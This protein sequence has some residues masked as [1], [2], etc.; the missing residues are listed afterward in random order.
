MAAPET[1]V[2]GHGDHQR[3]SRADDA[4]ELGERRAVVVEV[5]EHVES[6]REVEFVVGERQRLE[7]AVDHLA[8]TASQRPP[9]ALR[10]GLEPD[11]GPE[12]ADLR[13]H[14]A[15]PAAGVEDPRAGCVRVERAAGRGEHDRAPPAIPPMV[16]LGGERAAL[17]LG[18]HAGGRAPPYGTRPSTYGT[19]STF[20]CITGPW[21]K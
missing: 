21:P 5:L 15:A 13:E 12:P 8:G 2:G 20:S 1:R 11:R 14:R 9:A 6:Q 4:T 19:S 3:T 18:V 7:A 17:E 16:V 10:R